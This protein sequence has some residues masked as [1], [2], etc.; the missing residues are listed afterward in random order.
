[1]S[2]KNKKSFPWKKIL[3]WGL[4]LSIAYLLFEYLSLPYVRYL[5]TQN[6]KQTALMQ[7]R[8]REHKLKA[9]PYKIYQVWIPYS[10]ISPALCHSVVK[11]EDIGFWSNDGFEYDAMKRALKKD[12]DEGQFVHGAS[13]ITQ[14][15]AKN[16]F[17]STTKTFTRKIKEAILTKRLTKELTK[18]RILEL[19]LNEVEFGDGIFGCE[20]ASR[21]YFNKSCSD[22]T[23]MEAAMLAATLPQPLS[24]NPKTN[25]QRLRN[26]ALLLSD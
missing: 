13:T 5:K 22:L 18:K 20:A 16:L 6:P 12:W 23:P 3:F 8:I 7:Q 11:A 2:R 9:K 19:Y 21:I 24:V 10:K 14:Q 17:L 26:R 15:L 1:M 4:I 25:T